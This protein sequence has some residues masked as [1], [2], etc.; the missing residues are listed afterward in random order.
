MADKTWGDKLEPARSTH[1]IVVHCATLNVSALCRIVNTIMLRMFRK[2]S[3]FVLHYLLLS[4]DVVLCIYLEF[5]LVS[6]L[7]NYTG[8][9]A[10]RLRFMDSVAGQ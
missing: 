5:S 10:S 2:H 7:Q 9:D 8:E 1:Y 3:F 6:S 4:V